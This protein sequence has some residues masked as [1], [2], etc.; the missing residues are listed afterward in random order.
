MGLA[1]KSPKSSLVDSLAWSPMYSSAAGILAGIIVT[2][3]TGGLAAWGI[4]V[5]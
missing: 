3:V 5:R 1:N 4:A 2:A